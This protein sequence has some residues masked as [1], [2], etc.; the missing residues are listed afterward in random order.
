M[1]GPQPQRV[2]RA[3]DFF[4]PANTQTL[5]RSDTVQGR[6]HARFRRGCGCGQTKHRVPSFSGSWCLPVLGSVSSAKMVPVPDTFS[7]ALTKFCRRLAGP[8]P[9]PPPRA[10]RLPPMFCCLGAVGAAGLAWGLCRPD[11][12]FVHHG[13][14]HWIKF[15][16][17]PS[18]R[19]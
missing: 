4:P 6:H 10:R 12:E 15:F 8:P 9:T 19:D 2:K 14:T 16:L 7:W 1:T 17:S 13:V 18:R 3:W 5:K 11:Q